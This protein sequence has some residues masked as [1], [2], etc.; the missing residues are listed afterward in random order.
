[1]KK[2]IQTRIG[3]T[4]IELLVVIAIITILA[5]MLLPALNQARMSA[6][7]TQ[8]MNAL[9]S[10]G[11]GLALYL[12]DFNDCYVPLVSKYS[13]DWANADW[14]RHLA[15]YLG[16]D[17]ATRTWSKVMTCPFN[18]N[19]IPGVTGNALYGA[20]NLGMYGMN[21]LFG[22][23]CD[24]NGVFVE[25]HGWTGGRVVARKASQVKNPQAGIFFDSKSSECVGYWPSEFGQRLATFAHHTNLN[26]AAWA[27]DLAALS[28][29]ARTNVLHAAGNAKPHV[30][31]E[32]LLAHDQDWSPT[33][34]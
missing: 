29:V 8:C 31:K 9:K 5:A 19:I 27:V 20:A 34:R 3:F 1:M 12:G 28:G 4:L 10:M 33:Y 17:P 22:G 13:S 14:P 15:P 6:K 7:N 30:T 18:S 11:S 16:E 32:L 2:P 26:Q 21:N 25:G 23:Y 24:G